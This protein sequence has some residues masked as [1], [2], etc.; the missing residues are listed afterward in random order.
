MPDDAT[1]PP[2]KPINR[3]IASNRVE[4]TTVYGSDGSK[5]G[6]VHSFLVDKITGQVPM[7][8]S[9]LAASLG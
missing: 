4:G 7:R 2:T 5:V 3:L 8:C 9:L 6:T 1:P